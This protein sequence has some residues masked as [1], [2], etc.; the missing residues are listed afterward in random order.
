MIYHTTEKPSR[1]YLAIFI[2]LSGQKTHNHCPNASLLLISLK[3]MSCSVQMATEL[4][5]NQA[6]EE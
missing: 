2:L 5:I 3:R 1:Y 6:T 4:L